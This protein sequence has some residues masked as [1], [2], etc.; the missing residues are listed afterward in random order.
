MPNTPTAS[1]PKPAGTGV[2]TDCNFNINLGPT[3]YA[4]TE[5]IITV[6]VAVKIEVTQIHTSLRIVQ[7]SGFSR[8]LKYT[9]KFSDAR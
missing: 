4:G 8:R 7:K 6:K 2:K 9:A 5:C 3:R 1:R